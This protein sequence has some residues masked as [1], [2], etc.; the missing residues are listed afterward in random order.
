[1]IKK[2]FES[3]DLLESHIFY[4]SNIMPNYL[5]WVCFKSKVYSALVFIIN[6]FFF[7]FI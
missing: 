7:V 5:L 4:L 1:M 2:T 3:Y 6:F